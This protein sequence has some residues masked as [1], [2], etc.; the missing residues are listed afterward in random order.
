M[1]GLSVQSL[2]ISSNSVPISRAQPKQRAASKSRLPA[3]RGASSRLQ[4]K[5]TAPAQPKRRGPEPV[6][7]DE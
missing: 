6:T 7:R 4:A 3:A 1:N 2:S 5:G